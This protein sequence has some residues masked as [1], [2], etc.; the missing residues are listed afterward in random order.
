MATASLSGSSIISAPALSTAQTQDGGYIVGGWTTSYGGGGAD[1]YMLKV[2]ADGVEEWHQAYG[3]AGDDYADFGVGGY[4]IWL[5]RTDELGDSTWSLIFGGVWDDNARAVISPEE[6]K[7]IITGYTTDISGSRKAYLGSVSVLVSGIFELVDSPLPDDYTLA[8]NYP[9]PFNASTMIRFG[10]PEKSH[11]TVEVFNA[12]GR[13]VTTLVDGPLSAGN[14]VV[15]W[16][17]TNDIGETVATGVY[18]YRLSTD[19]S[20]TTRKMVL[21]K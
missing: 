18:L 17:G 10:L 12:L 9:N 5:I 15:D 16:D 14:Y 3:G 4:D 21:L 1:F 2:D 11:V 7:F 6:D 13:K 8:Q 19:L 20:T